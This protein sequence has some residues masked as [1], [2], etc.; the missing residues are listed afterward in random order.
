[1]PKAVQAAHARLRF[2]RPFSFRP[3]R[4][5]ER[6]LAGGGGS[7]PAPRDGPG[8]STSVRRRPR[9]FF[10]YSLVV[11]PQLVILELGAEGLAGDSQALGGA[12]LVALAHSEGVF[13]GHSLERFERAHGPGWERVEARPGDFGAR[14]DLGRQ[15]LDPDLVV[16]LEQQHALDHVS[17]LADVARPV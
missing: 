3:R 11:V 4:W 1:M 8:P 10:L 13:D 16:G 6:F 17:Q 9:L 5:A 2:A 7:K 15:V 14:G 12:G